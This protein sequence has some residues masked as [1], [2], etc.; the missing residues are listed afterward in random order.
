MQHIGAYVNLG[1]YYLVCIPVALFFAFVMQFRGQ[2]LWS[3]LVVG[4]MV[5]SIALSLVTFFT[6]W[7]KQVSSSTLNTTYFSFSHNHHLLIQ[8][9]YDFILQAIQARQRIFSQGFEVPNESVCKH[10]KLV[11]I[12]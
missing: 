1:A 10:E 3:G 9:K 5:Q 8:P 12:L 11:E 6:H 2:G 7:D 4:A